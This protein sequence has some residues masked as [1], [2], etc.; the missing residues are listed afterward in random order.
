MGTTRRDE[1]VKIQSLPPSLSL[2]LALSLPLFFLAACVS[3]RPVVKI[4]LVA[5]FEG[6]YRQIGYE[7]LAAMRVAIEESETN[8]FEVMPLAVDS[9]TDPA[10][11]RRTVQKLLV[12]PSVRAVVGPF[13]PESAVAVADLLDPH[14]DGWFLPFLP[15][16]TE[17]RERAL[18]ALIAAI[19]AETSGDN[20]SP[21]VLAGW[22][23]GWPDLSAAAWSEQVGRPVR[24]SSDAA[25]VAATETIV[26]LGNA[27]DGASYLIQLRSYRPDVPF[28]LAVG[29]DASIFYQRV[30]H[31]LE[32]LPSPPPLGPVYWA[33]WLDDGYEGW[34]ATHTPSSPIA[35]AVYR[36]TQAAVAEII[37]DPSQSSMPRLYV[38]QVSEDGQ[39]LPFNATLWMLE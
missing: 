37:G 11:V 8:S 26:W 31:R 30:A 3:T 21:L 36:A 13:S 17:N 2:F 18:V 16:T 1:G 22:S 27:V 34:A 25:D 28:W 19:A 9:G 35:Y 6:L 10:Q 20:E 32:M 29:G 12:D 39:Y 33:A 4:G 15:S 7:A 38:F 24:L 5:P 14:T 23:A